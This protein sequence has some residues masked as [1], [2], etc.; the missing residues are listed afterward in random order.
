[1]LLPNSYP[2]SIDGYT[3]HAARTQEHN[4]QIYSREHNRNVHT[5]E[6]NTEHTKHTA[7]MC[8]NVH[9]YTTH[10]TM[11]TAH[12]CTRG[13]TGTQYI[14][15]MYIHANT[16]QHACTHSYTTHTAYRAQSI[17]HMYTC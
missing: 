2:M 6:R 10:G 12:I 8:M 3:K 17:A 7:C 15:C 5:Q 16:T 13:H 14:A 4:M 1:M 9:S 11:Y